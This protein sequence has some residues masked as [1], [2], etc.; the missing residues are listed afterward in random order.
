MIQLPMV[1]QAYTPQLHLGDWQIVV[2]V[3]RRRGR[4]S[5][6]RW[7]S[8]EKTFHPMESSGQLLRINTGIRAFRRQM[9]VL[10][11]ALEKIEVAHLSDEEVVRAVFRVLASVYTAAPE[12]DQLCVGDDSPL[13]S[14]F[15]EFLENREKAALMALKATV[16]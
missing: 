15:A 4:I 1:L 11:T 13:E 8:S 2:F 12:R 16:H 7:H 14:E 3:N 10:A 6:E 9:P 5:V